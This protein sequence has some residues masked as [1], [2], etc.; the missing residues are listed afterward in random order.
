MAGPFHS[1]PFQNFRTSPIGVVPK[2]NSTKF[3]MIT[4]LSSPAGSSIND[5]IPDTES[6]VHFNNFDS[7]VKIIAN[8]GPN[9]QM[10]KI[11]I[12]SA[13]RICPVR[14]EDWHYLGFSFLG[15]YFVD[16]CLPFGL[17]SSVQRFTQLSDTISWIMQNNYNIHNSTHYLDDFFLAAV[18]Y[19][20][21]LLNLHKTINLFHTL[22]VPLAADKQVGPTSKITYLGIDIDTTSMSLSLPDEKLSDLIV[23]LT[24]WKLKKKCTKK[25][26]L[27]LIGKLSFACKI[28]PSGRT[29]LRRLIDLSTTVTSLHHHISLNSEARLDI[30]WWAKYLPDW[31]GRYKILDPHVTIC[32]DHNIF[33]DASGEIGFG[34]FNNGSWVAE[35]WPNNLLN[36]SIQWKELFPIYICCSIWAPKFQGKRLLFHCDNNAVVNI[37]S[38][39][40]SKCPQIMSLLRNLFYI[41]AKHEFTVNVKHIPGVN[42]TLADRLSR[43]QLDKFRNMAPNADKEPTKVPKDLWPV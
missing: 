3:R 16:L 11:D 7:A 35:R 29:F 22:G 32:H 15:M 17:R 21:C 13:F 37:W 39:N 30:Y 20:Q 25:S 38:S 26:L 1:P 43:L 23:L 28:I 5:F 6:K 10:A 2:K 24:R 4:D 9:S 18:D 34:I 31:N 33:T 42:N 27:S 36:R 40:S 19:N 41:A 12:K 14:R 8:L